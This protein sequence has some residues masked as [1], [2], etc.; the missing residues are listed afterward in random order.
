M[1]F[2]SLKTSPKAQLYCIWDEKTTYSLS[3]KTS[4]FLEAINTRS[5]RT[6]SKSKHLNNDYNSSS[7]DDAFV[8]SIIYSMLT[9]EISFIDRTNGTFD[10]DRVLQFATDMMGLK[11]MGVAL[12]DLGS[13]AIKEGWLVDYNGDNYNDNYSSE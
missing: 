10:N 2:I 9:S 13:Y 11:I 1:I 7:S 6:S 4:E 8:A 12:K 3:L 5:F